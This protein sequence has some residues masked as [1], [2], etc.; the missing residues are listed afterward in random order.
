MFRAHTQNFGRWDFLRYDGQDGGHVV[1]IRVCPRRHG[2]GVLHNTTHNCT[3]EF[4]ERRVEVDR[5]VPLETD[6]GD[7][8]G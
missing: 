3:R 2:Q 7:G 4:S 6:G 1:G 8:G 5:S